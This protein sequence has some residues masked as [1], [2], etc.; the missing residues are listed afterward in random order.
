MRSRPDV[1]VKLWPEVVRPGDTLEVEVALVGKTETPID[2]VRV[3]LRSLEHRRAGKYGLQHVHLELAGDLG[4]LWLKAGE[5]RLFPCRFRLPPDLPPSFNGGITSIEHRLTV[6]LD[7]PWWPDRVVDYLV[8]VRPP[9]S[10]P[11][12]TPRVF[13]TAPEGPRGSELILE[14][15]LHDT[16]LAPGGVIEGEASLINAEQHRVRRLLAE[17]VANDEPTPENGTSVVPAATFDPI[18][19]CKGPPQSGVSYP[20]RFQLPADAMP[21]FEAALSRLVWLVQV[22]AEIDFATDPTLSSVITVHEA[23]P[24]PLAKEPAR[25]AP[26]LGAE[27]RAAIWREVADAADLSLDATANLSLDAAAERLTGQVG[28]VAL[29]I[30]L[31]LRK[32]RLWSVAE[33]EWP[34]ARLGLLLREH[35]WL[36][37]LKP[38]LQSG[39]GAFDAR[40]F[41]AGRDPAQVLALLDHPLR[42][43]LRTFE[44][45]ELD[46]GGAALAISDNGHTREGLERFVRGC[47]EV[48]RLVDGA[49]AALPV[50]V[51]L[52]ACRPAW[53]EQA[54]Q[55]SGTFSPGDFSIRGARYRDLDVELVT[56][57]EGAEPVATLARVKLGTPPPEPLPA[58]AARVLASLSAE[59]AG[60]RVAADAVELPLACPLPNPERAELSWRSLQ[61]LAQALAPPA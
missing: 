5:R 46:D 56:R 57:F 49:L 51:K 33:L 17:L 26:P 55:L 18:P 53:Q 38:D 41:L 1:E 21:S 20:F 24:P 32:D 43:A 34:D 52:E 7:I 11:R 6:R 60:V 54:K 59:V 27:R 23:R 44:A 8:V 16:E 19:I 25:R 61:R 50:P 37:K 36:D 30:F 9:L 35:R 10:Q 15:A 42:T 12:R 3:R 47:L 22:R 40:F 48:A 31:E 2:A 13:S 39:D 4:A 14:V 45:V 28:A 29:S 58:E